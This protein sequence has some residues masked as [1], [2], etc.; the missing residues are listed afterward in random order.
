MIL[1][2]PVRGHDLPADDPEAL[3]GRIDAAPTLLAADQ[4]AGTNIDETVIARP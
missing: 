3:I 1:I 2:D 4:E